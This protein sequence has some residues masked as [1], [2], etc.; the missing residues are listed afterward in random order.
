MTDLDLLSLLIGASIALSLAL[1]LSL[2]MLDGLSRAWVLTVGTLAMC[3][4]AYGLL[5][6]PAVAQ[7]PEAPR[8]IL[9]A[10][11]CSGVPLL[12]LV[13]RRLFGDERSNVLGP[14]L[15]A[16]GCAVVLALLAVAAA[17]PGTAR[18]C[19]ALLAVW[20]AGWLAWMLW[21]VWRGRRDDLEE[22]R[23]RL[24]LVLVL[25][26]LLYVVVV[27]GLQAAGLRR[28][29]PEL[30]ALGLTTVQVVFKLAVLALCVGHPSPLQEALRTSRVPEPPVSETLQPVD[31]APSAAQSLAAHRVAVNQALAS[32]QARQVLDRVKQDALYRRHGLSIGDLAEVVDLPEHRLRSVINGHLGFKNFAA[33]LN[34]FRLREAAQRLRD[35]GFAHL[36]VL[37]IALDAGFASIGPFNRAFRAAFGLT[38]TD[39]R[40]APEV[41][42]FESGLELPEVGKT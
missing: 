26:C 11:A 33:F 28:E 7:G 34:H 27:L 1:G 41:A 16:L 10:L 38:P 31:A 23:R 29:A 21:V 36:P 2:A 19:M 12:A 24:R 4:A 25:G 37:T 14:P 17:W 9:R 13:V 22:P 40:R 42:G 20:L 5:A 6:L 35:P 8:F 15:V 3:G 39:Y 18:A 32:R 30:I